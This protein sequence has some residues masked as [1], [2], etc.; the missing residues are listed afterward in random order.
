VGP[1]RAGLA[2]APTLPED[3]AAA[4]WSP[5]QRLLAL[6]ESHALSGPALHAWCREKGLF[7][8]QLLQWRDAFC[9]AGQAPAAASAAE[10][11]L[12]NT[13]QRELR[14]KDR[15][16]AE[17]AAL[18]VLQKK[19][20]ASGAGF[21]AI[22]GRGH[23]SSIAQRATLL[24]LV[25]E[26]CCASAGLH[27]ACALIGLAARTV[28]RWRPASLIKSTAGECE[29]RARI[30]PPSCA[31]GSSTCTCLWTCSAACVVGWQVFDSERDAQ[32]DK[33]LLQAR[34]E[35]YEAARQQNPRRWSGQTR[36]W[37]FISTATLN[38]DKPQ[39][40]ETEAAKEV[41]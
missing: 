21:T 24:G 33:A 9:C 6:N 22:G 3:V 40:K 12:A 10:Q 23:M 2:H 19:F 4:Q 31:G 39:P 16:L 37:N 15:A 18:L 38:P 1:V 17:A 32:L 36:R 41:A 5:A 34:E 35:V 8:H 20:Q 11:R 27:Q 26:A 29:K 14:C 25:H 30:C 7:E 28:Q 13:L